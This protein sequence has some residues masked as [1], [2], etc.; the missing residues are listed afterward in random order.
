MKEEFVIFVPPT[1]E[2]HFHT[3]DALVKRLFHVRKNFV[4]PSSFD[5]LIHV[6]ALLKYLNWLL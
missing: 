1:E 2:G 5:F 6:N 4:F 3:P